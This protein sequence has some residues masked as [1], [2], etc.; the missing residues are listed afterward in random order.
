MMYLQAAANRKGT[1]GEC[2]ALVG[3][4]HVQ[5]FISPAIL[6]EVRDVLSRPKIRQAFPKLTDERVADFLDWVIAH[7]AV[8]ADVAVHYALPRDPDDEPYLNLALEVQSEHLVTWDADLLSLKNDE[9][10]GKHFPHLIIS[11]PHAFL[12]SVRADISRQLG[13]E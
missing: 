7:G 1:A 12:Q 6:A 10:F 4:G 11:T 13:Y 2:F 3:D 9:V 5:L 8:V